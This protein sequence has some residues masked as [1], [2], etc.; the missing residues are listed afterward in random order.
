MDEQG[1]CSECHQHSG[2]EKREEET[3][4]LNAIIEWLSGSAGTEE[5][6]LR[7]GEGAEV[8]SEEPRQADGGQNEIEKLR[9]ELSQAR[10]EMRKQSIEL[11]A[12]RSMSTH[13]DAE[14]FARLTDLASIKADYERQLSERDGRIKE[15]SGEVDFGRE[16]IRELEEKIRKREQDI[17]AHEI[18]LQHREQ[19]LTEELRKIELAKK[20]LGSLQELELKKSMEELRESVREKEE[21][22]RE[23]EKFLRQKED[24]LN[25]REQAIIRKEVEVFEAIAVSELKQ[26]RVKSGVSRLD[27]LLLGG[28]PAGSQVLIYGPSFIGKE[29]AMNAFAAEGLRKGVPLIWIT[30]DKSVR[31]IREEMSFV[32]NNFE[33]YERMGLVFYV[34]AYS[35]S[36]G[37]K[38][39]CE[40]TA[41]IE[42]SGNLE[43]ID[44]IVEE[45][46]NSMRETVEKK[47]YRIVFR[48]I[49]SLTA[50]YDA[51]SIFK[52]MR[53]FI[54]KRKRDK[55]VGMYSVE[56]G[57]A[58]D[59]DF[60]IISSIMDGVINFDTDGQN[61]YLSVTGICEVQTRERIKYTANK[62]SLTI[63][64]FTI[65]HV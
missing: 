40:N 12:L 1:Y 17:E 16:K 4:D 28:I 62:S 31:E 22:I 18:D 44:R 37:E 48:S 54:A 39:T 53:P 47:S 58:S 9:E 15:L 5:A 52:L 23:L 50:M 57:M 63:G 51:K 35:R 64:S 27:D 21:K 46:V 11:I 7:E 33:E 43:D 49:S 3:D 6:F 30:T 10:E 13:I 25:R 32:L 55:S 2:R 56:K 41:Y 45:K 34:D 29:V 14:S 61:N 60:Q 38:E 20:E 65:G 19:V 36:V 26:E 8:Q 42:D 24:E 59:Q